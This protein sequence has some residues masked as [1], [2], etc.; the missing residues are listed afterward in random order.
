MIGPFDAGVAR[1]EI[2]IA[3]EAGLAM[4]SPATRSPCL[5]RNVF[6]P[7]NLNPARTEIGCKMAGLPPPTDLRPANANNFFRLSAT[8]DPQGEAASDYALNPLHNMRAG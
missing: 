3:N 2:P 6:M 5:T 1:K 8:D 4:I 7:A